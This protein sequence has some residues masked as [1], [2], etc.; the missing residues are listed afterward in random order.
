MEA[1]YTPGAP[2]P[3]ILT[4]SPG[5]KEQETDAAAWL[6]CFR[7]NSNCDFI[8][9]SSKQGTD[10]NFTNFHEFGKESLRTALL[11]SCATNRGDAGKQGNDSRPRRLQIWREWSGKPTWLSGHNGW[12]QASCPD[13]SE[14][15]RRGFCALLAGR[16]RLYI[17]RVTIGF[18]RHQ[19]RHPPVRGLGLAHKTFG[20]ARHAQRGFCR[21]GS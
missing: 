16:S 12:W 15:G 11:K 21:S 13:L 7:G 6:G 8:A 5:A 9:E 20:V 2:F 4:F 3:L 1:G 18:I 17:A 19:C 14:G 10:A